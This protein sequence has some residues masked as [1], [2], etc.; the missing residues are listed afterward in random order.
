M[1]ESIRQAGVTAR[2]EEY[3]VSGLNLK[4]RIK[5][6]KQVCCIQQMKTLVNRWPAGFAVS[7][8][9]QSQEG[10]G[11]EKALSRALEVS[12]GMSICSEVALVILL[13]KKLYNQLSCKVSQILL[14]F[15]SV[16]KTT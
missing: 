14:C 11:R 15:D 1:C 16:Y 9:A 10:G 13:G 6:P 7:G 12:A 2:Q 3:R 4:H 5:V 8:S